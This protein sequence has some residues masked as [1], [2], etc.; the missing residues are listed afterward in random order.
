MHP[1]LVVMIAYALAK[2]APEVLPEGLDLGALL[3]LDEVDAELKRDIL[4][5]ALKRG[6]GGLLLSLGASFLD[7]DL[8]PHPLVLMFRNCGG[9]SDLL[10]KQERLFHFMRPGHR[11]QTI[12]R[13]REQLVVEHITSS[14]EPTDPVEALYVAGLLYSS[15]LYVGCQS[16]SLSLPLTGDLAPVLREGCAREPAS[17]DGCH[18]LSYRWEGELSRR[19][20]EG[21]DTYLLA[22]H[23]LKPLAR[24]QT[25]SDRVRE[26]LCADLARRWTPPRIARALSISPRSLQRR[27]AEEQTTFSR[28]LSEER[29]RAAKQLLSSGELSVTEIGLVTGYADTAHFARRFREGTGMSPSEWRAKAHS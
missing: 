15:L 21:L 19:P 29:L 11:L 7:P 8:P 10:D 23:P 2:Q 6:G 14:G 12:E 26:L 22:N 27:L 18:R 1:I 25:L 3:R 24:P 20:V 9:V 16:L 17:L 4:R 5:R 13:S 28:L